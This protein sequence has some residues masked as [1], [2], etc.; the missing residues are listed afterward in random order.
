MKNLED[1]L[2]MLMLMALIDN[3]RGLNASQTSI[4]PD[5]KNITQ[6]FLQHN[7]TQEDLNYFINELFYWEQNDWTWSCICGPCHCG[8]LV[9]RFATAYRAYHGYVSVLVCTFGTLT[10]ITNLFVLT[11][12]EFRLAPINRILTFM[13]A[14]DMLV[15][16]E[17]IPFA[18][19]EYIVLPKQRIFPY[20]W[21][22][23]VL[24]HMHFSQFL[25]TISIALTVTLA[26]WRYIV[27]RYV[28]FFFAFQFSK[29][30]L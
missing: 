16:L 12:K 28:M 6:L 24:F 11:R 23:F 21:A 29:K 2:L 10:N 15:M 1:N 25:H 20:G 30:I 22:V 14:A 19:Y 3:H 18:V 5:W 4:K 26:I 9:R 7:V 17:Y 13:A 8:G 27:V